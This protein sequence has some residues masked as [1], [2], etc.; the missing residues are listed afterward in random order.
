MEILLV[1]TPA[2]DGGLGD[3]FRT[4]STLPGHPPLDLSE[5][6]FLALASKYGMVPAEE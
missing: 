6:E 5:E 1:T 3:Y 2:E 4:A